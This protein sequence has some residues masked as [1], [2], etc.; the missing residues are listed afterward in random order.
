MAA[1]GVNNTAADGVIAAG[2]TPA[3]SELEGGHACAEI[4][5]RDGEAGKEV[6]SVEPNATQV[7]RPNDSHING[8]GVAMDCEGDE[9]LG[10]LVSQSL[11][12]GVGKVEAAEVAGPV[13][14][15]TAA[16][17]QVAAATP[18]KHA[19]P[20]DVGDEGKAGEPPAE[21]APVDSKAAQAPETTAK[22][23][24]AAAPP[25]EHAAS[26]DVGDEGMVGEPPAEAAAVVSKAAP[27]AQAQ[28]T[29]AKAGA[30]ASAS[31]DGPQIYTT[32]CGLSYEESPGREMLTFLRE[33]LLPQYGTK[34]QKWLR[35]IVFDN[36]PQEEVDRV[37]R[38]VKAEDEERSSYKEKPEK[39]K[40]EKETQEKGKQA[41]DSTA[42]GKT[43]F[44]AEQ[45]KV[46][47]KRA[48][49]EKE[50]KPRK[51][52]AVSIDVDVPQK[53][54]QAPSE[55]VAAPIAKNVVSVVAP[56]LC[57]PRPA[58]SAADSVEELSRRVS[59]I[60]PTSQALIVT[61][62]RGKNC[63]HAEA[64]DLV[65]FVEFNLAAS[66]RQVPNLSKLWKCPICCEPAPQASLEV[67]AELA[68]ILAAA[69]QR[70]PDLRYV[71][72]S[73]SGALQLP[74]VGSVDPALP[75][76]VAPSIARP[77][78]VGAEP[79]SRL[80]ARP[81]APS[82]GAASAA[83]G[84]DEP[85][86]LLGKK[87][88]LKKGPTSTGMRVSDG[89]RKA[90]RAPIVMD[91][92]RRHGNTIGCSGCNDIFKREKVTNP[93]LRWNFRSNHNPECVT[94]FEALRRKDPH[95]YSRQKAGSNVP[96]A[97]PT[98]AP[99]SMPNVSTSPPSSSKANLWASPAVCPT[100]SPNKGFSSLS[101]ALRTPEAKGLRAAPRG[102][103][104]NSVPAVKGLIGEVWF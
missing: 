101:G 50:M 31:G 48:R 28:E 71:L 9:S 6:D 16:E 11:D 78:A 89:T 32:P 25:D 58:S 38:L 91:D 98:E 26:D 43:C 46:G 56:K 75:K 18:D 96:Q 30:S 76:V 87:V 34:A 54:V 97:P 77:Q 7:G 61:P 93:R 79:R 27:A 67:H 8:G 4:G 3:R 57:T 33:H 70:R 65:N 14:P 59:L 85:R 94:R 55:K 21:A 102:S 1:D 100:P 63:K 37:V 88:V 72:V 53:G 82:S 81:L 69:R 64:F 10:G 12:V 40:Q 73:P 41:K 17:A 35:I 19:A 44:G 90:A 103:A 39:E 5:R 47:Q 99:T 51:R 95:A 2:A 29:K 45:P 36:A 42:A 62:V 52:L 13:E 22:A 92:M 66:R 49:I 15:D 68:R 84:A 83:K 23:Q 80:P 74:D 24:V 86:Q 20:D 104:D 60:D